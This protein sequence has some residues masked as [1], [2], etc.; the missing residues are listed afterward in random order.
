MAVYREGYHAVEEIQKASKQ[1]YPDAADY[2]APVKKGDNLWNLANQLVEWY[3]APNKIRER[4]DYG[5]GTTVITW[6][7]LMDEWAVSDNRKS[8]K[9]AMD[10]YKITYVQVKNNRLPGYDGYI[11]IEKH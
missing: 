9:E 4:Y 11:Y 10:L 7:E 3:P 8:V 6:A 5:T 1:I 2:G